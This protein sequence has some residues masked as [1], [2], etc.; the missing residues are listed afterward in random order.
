M[1]PQFSSKAYY[2]TEDKW[3]FFVKC[4]ENNL[5]V[6]KT[7]LLSK[8]LNLIKREL[9]EF[10]CWPVILKRIEGACGDYVEK[11]DNYREALRIIKRFRKKGG[12]SIP[13][14]A[15]ELIKSPSY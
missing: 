14:I 15:Q 4:K 11:A 6:P 2:Y 5:P 13:I 7:N 12:R 3:M 1:P 10:N 9:E 8:N